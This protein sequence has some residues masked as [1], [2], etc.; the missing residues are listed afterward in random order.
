MLKISNLTARVDNKLVLNGLSLEVNDGEIHAIMGKN[1]IGKSTLCK[2]IMRDLNY[3]ILGG[4]I[5]YNNSDL[6]KMTTD[7]VARCGIMLIGQNPLAIE[8]ITNAELLR[9]SLRENKNEKINLFAF[10]QKMEEACKKLDMD[11]KFIHKE[12]NVGASGGERK[13]IELLHMAVL[14]PSFVVLDEDSLK[15]VANFINEYHKKTNCSILLITHHPNIINYIKPNYVHVLD[16][17]QV[18]NTGD[19]H[20]AE[21]IEKNGYSGASVISE[22]DND[23]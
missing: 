6:L 14:E 16:N 20:L 17:G 19:Y 4:N 13:K 7:E 2:I 3:E 12:I 8:G 1:G 15:T 5:I 9:A 11:P 10:N 21:T 23:E 22:S 18:V